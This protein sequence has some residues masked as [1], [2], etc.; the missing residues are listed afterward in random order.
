MSDF[1]DFIPAGES[2]GALKKGFVDFVPSE[3]PKPVEQP[4]ETPAE[5]PAKP[6]SKK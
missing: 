6:K 1:R 3:T 2:S 4:V 5:E